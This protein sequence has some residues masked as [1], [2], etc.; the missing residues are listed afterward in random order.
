MNFYTN[1]LTNP[2]DAGLDLPDINVGVQANTTLIGNGN[3]GGN[4][5]F[6]DIDASNTQ[7]VGNDAG[8][9]PFAPFYGGWDAGDTNVGVQANTTQIGNGNSGGNLTFGDIDASNEQF[10]GNDDFIA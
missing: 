3:L 10:V 8:A 7:A 9:A 5:T 4:L 1:W 2:A 6:G